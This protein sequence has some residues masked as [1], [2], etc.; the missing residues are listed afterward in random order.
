MAKILMVIAAKGY[1][2]I[3]YETPKEILEQNG[4]TVITTSTKPEAKGS[5]GGS[6]KVDILLKKV[7]PKDY[8]AITFIGGPGSH[9]LIKNRKTL[10]LAKNFYESGKLTTAICAAPAI[11]ANAGI[12]EG[13]TATCHEGQ[14]QTLIKKEANY[15]GSPV[16]QDSNIITASGPGAAR[17]FGKKIAKAI[18]DST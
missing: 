1:Q 9:K 11:L 17:D 3:E 12:L 15:T 4:H 16:E 14:S 5:L 8:D 2:D 10:S 7:D 6:T 13:K 18:S